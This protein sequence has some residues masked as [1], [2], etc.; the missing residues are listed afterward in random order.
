MYSYLSICC[1]KVI[2]KTCPSA[3]FKKC[4]I[5]FSKTLLQNY[6]IETN[7]NNCTIIDRF[8]CEKAIIVAATNQAVLHC[9]F[10]S[11]SLFIRPAV[12]SICA[13]HNRPCGLSI[14]EQPNTHRRPVENPI[15]RFPGVF[16]A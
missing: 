2:V 14:M 3:L 5:Y 13:R 4:S 10:Y 6:A 8:V 16:L 12:S 7:V 11:K 15:F 1:N 9:Y